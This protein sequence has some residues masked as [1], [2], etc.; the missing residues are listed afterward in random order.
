MIRYAIVLP[1]HRN[2]YLITC[3]LPHS[4]PPSNVLYCGV[5]RRQLAPKV[6]SLPIDFWSRLLCSIISNLSQI[7]DVSKLNGQLEVSPRHSSEGSELLRYAIAP[8]KEMN[9]VYIKPITIDEGV[10]IW[11]SGMIYNH[12]DIKFSIF[13]CVSE[14]STVEEQGIE[15]CCTQDN[16]GYVIMAQLC[17]LVQRSLEERFPYLFST[18]TP[19]QKHELTQIAICP[20][21]LEKDERNPSYFLIEACVHALQLKREYKCRCHPE[22]LPLGDLIPD[23]LLLEFPSQLNLTKTMFEYNEV[24]PLHRGRQTVLHNGRFNG[25]E[26]VIKMY[27]QI[28]SRSITLPLSW[29]RREIDMLSSLNH[30]NIIQSFGFCLDPACVLVEKAPLGSLYQMLIDSKVKISRTVRFHVGCQVASALSY[31]HQHDIIYRTL[32]SSS[33]LVWSLD[34]NYEASVKL[35]HL[36]RAAYQSPSG[37]MSKTT[38]SSYPTLEMLRYSFREEYTEKVDVYSFGIFLYELV[39][40]CQSYGEMDYGTQSQISKLPDAATTIYRTIVK[41]MEEC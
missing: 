19:L 8:P 26:V 27:Y 16:Y 7:V 25:K 34:F 33:I 30:P 36:E 1:T 35:T 2:Q 3:L 20:T 37:L 24:K 32:K 40:R 9:P 21:C 12:K 38:F 28:D 14:A 15:I 22:P 6:H 4:Q 13:P 5:L 11:E 10:E 39:T 23:Y 29:V 31:L 17:W 41:L 18:E